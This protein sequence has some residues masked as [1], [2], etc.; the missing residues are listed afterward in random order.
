MGVWGV[1]GNHE[2]H[3]GVGTPLEASGIRV[4]RDELAEPSPGLLLAGR[5]QARTHGPN[6]PGSAWVP[7]RGPRPGGL[8]LLSHAPSHS[9]EAAQARVGLMLSGHTHGG[10]IWPFGYLAGVDYPVTEGCTAID[11]MTLIV[12]RGTGTWGPWLRLWKRAEISLITLR[13]GT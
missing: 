12:N 4:L 7:C 11:G 1:D 8:I 3:G 9:R 10:Q 2:R 5:A 6:G 13:A